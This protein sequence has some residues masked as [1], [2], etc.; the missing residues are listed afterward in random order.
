MPL[1]RRRLPSPARVAR[2]ERPPTARERRAIDAYH[3]W[4][5]DT[6]VWKRT[7]WRGVMVQKWVGDLWSYA[8][9]LHALRPTLVVEVGTSF[10]GSALWF[11]DTM[12]AVAPPARVLTVDVDGERCAAVVRDD[13]RIERLVA[14][15]LDPAV[16]SRV[17]ALRAQRPGPVFLILDGNH[18]ADHV[19]AEMEAFRDVLV[20]GDVLVVEDGNVNGHPVLPEHGP[21][22]LEAVRAY[23][24]LR[25]DD[26]ERDLAHEARFGLTFAPEG[27][28]VRR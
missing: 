2:P 14:S 23:V 3:R 13:P 28:L 22:P 11:A 6:E 16:A 21:G 4:Y 1:F 18:A 12:S 25:P 15:S 26:Y 5:Y 19:L 27:F 8:E 10:G 9:I 17:R 7:T 20:R 24:A